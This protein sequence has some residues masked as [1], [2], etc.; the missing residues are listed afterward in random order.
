MRLRAFALG[1]LGLAALEILTTANGSKAAS[2]I[3]SGAGGFVQRVLDPTVPLFASNTSNAK[4]SSYTVAPATYSAPA[5]NP[6]NIPT[7]SYPV[8]TIPTTVPIPAT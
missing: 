4:T 6:T 1:I 3:A 7:T 8:T 5:P 2:G